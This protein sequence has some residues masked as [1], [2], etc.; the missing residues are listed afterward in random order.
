MSQDTVTLLVVIFAALLFVA[1]AA[2]YAWVESRDVL[3]E[4]D[5]H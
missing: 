5:R 2:W 1:G 4:L 3:F